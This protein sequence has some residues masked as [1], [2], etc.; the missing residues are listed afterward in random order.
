MVFKKN[1]FSPFKELNY[2]LEEIHS[3]LYRCL[4][5]KSFV[6]TDEDLKIIMHMCNLYSTHAA[7]ASYFQIC[8]SRRLREKKKEDSKDIN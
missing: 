8:M 2:K 3:V 7:F 4:N 6:P 5:N 1:L